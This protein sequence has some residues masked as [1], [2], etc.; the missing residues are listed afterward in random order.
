MSLVRPG[1]RYAVA[2]LA[3]SRHAHGHFD[4]FGRYAALGP[5]EAETS[6]E[7]RIRVGLRFPQSLEWLA[8]L[9]YAAYRFNA[10]SIWEKTAGLGDGLLRARYLLLDDA[11][12]HRGPSLARVGVSSVVRLPIGGISG[13]RSVSF[14]SGGAQLG[15]GAWE[16]GA[17]VDASR[18]LW[19]KLRLSLSSEGA[20]RLPDNALGRQRTLGP[21]LDLAVAA[22]YEASDGASASL[23][24]RERFTAN[25]KL[26]ERE[27]AGTGE[28]TFSLVAVAGL[29]DA[30]S[31]FRSSVTFSLEPALSGLSSGSTVAT[32]LG[33]ALGVGR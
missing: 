8:E 26:D 24:L 33:V 25:V 6:E 20:W 14:G 23:A 19:Q 27:L 10:P 17:G 16:L 9:G 2:L 31:G 13:G 5:G 7:L 21:R 30:A 22:S 32:A 1:E 12:P 18:E 4:A 15:L 28:R 3:S 29:Y 11:M